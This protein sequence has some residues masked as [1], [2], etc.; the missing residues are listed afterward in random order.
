MSQHFLTD[1]EIKQ[2]KCFTDFTASGFK[3]VNLIGGKN[4]IGKT[5]FME[6]CYVNVCSDNIKNFIATCIS[7]KFMRENMNLL[8][9]S[10]NSTDVEKMFDSIKQYIVKTNINEID[11]SVN[12]ENMAN[13][14]SI[15]VNQEQL[16]SNIIPLKQTSKNKIIFIDEYGWGDNTFTT[17]YQTIQQL[18]KEDELNNYLQLFDDTIKF[19]VIAG[20][21]KVRI[22]NNYFNIADLGGGLKRYLAIIF[23]LLAC[24]NGYLFIDNIGKDIHYSQ[25]NNLWTVLL[26]VSAKSNCQVFA[27]SHSKEVIDSFVSVSKVLNEQSISYMTLVKN[28][29]EQIKNIIYDDIM[30][31]CSTNQEDEMRGW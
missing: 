20:C 6:A 16:R 22:D 8:G 19:K 15:T 9:K 13:R 7:T 21:P 2:F 18:D 27:S 14:Y 5:A 4:N 10:L 23:A 29:N 24:Q 17:V 3:R 1:I 26:K 12:F 25:L 31:S 30:L 28:K 11:C